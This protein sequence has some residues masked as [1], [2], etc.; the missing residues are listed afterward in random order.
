[1]KDKSDFPLA[2]ETIVRTRNTCDFVNIGH[3]LKACT[4]EV[5]GK[6]KVTSIKKVCLIGMQAQKGLGL[7]L[8]RL[9]I[10]F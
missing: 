6:I 8:D 1:M 2:E 10:P 4:S 3:L 9:F 7:H 5:L